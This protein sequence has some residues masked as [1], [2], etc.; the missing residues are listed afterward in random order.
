VPGSI[1]CLS[2]RAISR[3]RAPR[4]EEC[5]PAFLV[6][7]AGMFLA[8]PQRM[9]AALT[10]KALSYGLMGLLWITGLLLSLVSIRKESR[11]GIPLKGLMGL[12][13]AVA[14]LC[15][16]VALFAAYADKAKSLE[17]I[18]RPVTKVVSDR[19]LPR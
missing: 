12:T 2:V 5:E 9:D 10:F 11:C 3:W 19:D 4:F 13:I 16:F 7:F 15:A 18:S 8:L 1:Y 14:G 17:K 6:N